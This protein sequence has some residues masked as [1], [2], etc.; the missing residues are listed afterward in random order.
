MKIFKALLCF[1]IL[2][3]F[4][5]SGIRLGE[6]YW[7]YYS[8][9]SKVEDIAKFEDRQE[10]ILPAVIGQAQ[11]IGIPITESDVTISGSKGRYIIETGWTEKVNLFDIYEHT[12]DFRITAGK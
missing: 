11:E 2:A 5:Y 6:P 1:G 8:F 4:A 10:N 9:K 7:R 12:Y 3:V